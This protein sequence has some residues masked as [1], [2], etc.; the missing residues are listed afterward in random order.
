MF[1]SLSYSSE[2]V[3]LRDFQLKSQ[4]SSQKTDEYAGS[5]DVFMS[6]IERYAKPVLKKQNESWRMQLVIAFF[7]E[8]KC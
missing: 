3:R 1:K 2:L 8:N 5:A 6:M 4:V 7:S